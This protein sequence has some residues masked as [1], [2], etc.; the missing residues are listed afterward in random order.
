MEVERWFQ[1]VTMGNLV[2]TRREVLLQII[3]SLFKFGI[4]DFRWKSIWFIPSSG[5]PWGN[6]TY[7]PYIPD[8]DEVSA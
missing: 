8:P 3:E 6:P 4:L 5:A 2:R 1:S 7:G